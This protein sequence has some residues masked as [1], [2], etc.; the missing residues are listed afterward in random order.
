MP[1][2]PL[3]RASQ[4]TRSTRTLAP[5]SKATARTHLGKAAPWVSKTIER[6]HG[7]RARSTRLI[8][9]ARSTGESTNCNLTFCPTCGH[10]V[11]SE[12]VRK[13]EMQFL[14]CA[15]TKDL[16]SAGPGKVRI[17]KSEL[18]IGRLPPLPPPAVPARSSECPAQASMHRLRPAGRAA[19]ARTTSWREGGAR[20]KLLGRS[21]W[22]SQ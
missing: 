6:S 15:S 14:L 22:N 17:A 12:E 10:R 21:Q 11:C 8:V 7:T 9:A 3:P 18:Q 16:N 2:H 4:G 19:L 5:T 20:N 13:P 1:R